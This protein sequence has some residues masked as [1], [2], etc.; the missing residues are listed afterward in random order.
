MQALSKI[1][2]MPGGQ[3]DDEL[4]QT[5]PTNTKKR[6]SSTDDSLMVLQIFKNNQSYIK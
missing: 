2:F 1:K 5:K 6:V 4:V 3:D